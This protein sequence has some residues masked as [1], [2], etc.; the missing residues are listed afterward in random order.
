MKL[1]VSASG[2][3]SEEFEVTVGIKQGCFMIPV[4]FD[5][6]VLFVRHLLHREGEK[7]GIDVRYRIDRKLYDL[8]ELKAMTNSHMK[9]QG[10]AACWRR[11]DRCPLHAATATHD[12]GSKPYLL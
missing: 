10:T 8:V 7:E 2:A 4:Q 11:N 9:H 1:T 12:Q 6:Y 5:V 3:I